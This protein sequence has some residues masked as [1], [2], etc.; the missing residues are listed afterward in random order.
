MAVLKRLDQFPIRS[1]YLLF[2]QLAHVLP[3]ELVA[4][5]HAEVLPGQSEQLA[6]LGDAL[7]RRVVD[8]V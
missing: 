3:V 6:L 1:D 4:L 2:D 7:Y 8:L 5:K